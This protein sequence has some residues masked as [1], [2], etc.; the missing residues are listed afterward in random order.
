M[1]T[2]GASINARALPAWSMVSILCV[3]AAGCA[4]VRPIKYYTI[5]VPVPPA[6]ATAT[7]YSITLQVARMASPP[8]MRAGGV[9]YL[10]GAN[11]IGVYSSHH[12][13]EPPDLMVQS[14]LIRVLRSSGKYQSVWER[15][16]IASSDYILRGTLYVFDDLADAGT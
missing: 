9:L 16:S 8:I 6:S 12:W 2:S 1:S 14:W 5:V 11:Q 3:L 10:T 13:A 15:N 4:S 7:P